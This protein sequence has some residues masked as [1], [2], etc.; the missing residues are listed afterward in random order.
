MERQTLVKK[1]GVWSRTD[2]R[3]WI[4][5]F[6]FKSFSLLPIENLKSK[7]ENQSDSRLFRHLFFLSA[8]PLER[9]TYLTVCHN[10]QVQLQTARVLLL[11]IYTHCYCAWLLN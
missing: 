1:S 4:C 11:T 8:L 9:G 6:R 5:D 2:F 10:G 7:I 3:F